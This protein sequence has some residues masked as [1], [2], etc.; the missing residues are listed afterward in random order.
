MKST[1]GKVLGA[2]TSAATF[3]AVIASAKDAKKYT[4]WNDYE[5]SA[6][7]AQYSALIQINKSNAPQTQGCMCSPCRSEGTS[8]MG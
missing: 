8:N 6:D 7:S 2:L 1:L 4:I 3:A 5:G